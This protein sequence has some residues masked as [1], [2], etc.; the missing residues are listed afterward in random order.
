MPRCRPRLRT[1]KWNHAA[2]AG[3]GVLTAC[4]M[5]A[6]EL[7]LPDLDLPVLP[8]WQHDISLRTGAGYRDNVGLSTLF[9][10]A[11]AFILT[12]AELFF[13]RLPENNTQFSFFLSVDDL[14]F[15]SSRTVDKEQTVFA[16]ALVENDF[17]S[18]W[19]ASLAAEYVYQ[20]QVV[21]LSATEPN[22]STIP[23]QGHTAILRPGL[24]HDFTS[25]CWM[26]VEAPLQRQLYHEPLDDYSE[27][28]GRLM[29]GRSYGHLSELSVRYEINR[30]RYD[31]EPLRDATGNAIPDSLRESVQQDLRLT[32]KHYWDTRRRWRATTKLGA[33]HSADS[34]S[35]YFD[36]TKLLAGEQILFR[37]EDWEISAEARF[38]RYDYPVQTV[39]AIDLAKRLSTEWGLN[40]RCER[41]LSRFVRIF[42]EYDRVES[43]SNLVFEQYA[44]N[45]VKSGL[46]WTF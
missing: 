22:V 4:L 38:A 23:V 45:T 17:R 3:L 21:D 19:Q 42:A 2:A 39:S 13:L 29:L 12:G 31:N 16:Q 44:V 30:R 7:D 46:N 28:G 11:S 15:L 6:Q 35:G 10:E 18:G 43:K 25:N 20:D 41:R 8:Q 26:T 37:T 33:R 40:F 14:R 34:G 24:R 1:A 27:Y 32:W 36:Y 5:Q 9:P